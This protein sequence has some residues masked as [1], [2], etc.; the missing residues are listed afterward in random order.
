MGS[1]VELMLDVQVS[2]NLLGTDLDPDHVTKQLGLQPT[3]MFRRGDKKAYRTGRVSV[4]KEGYWSYVVRGTELDP[5]VGEFVSA[6]GERRQI[7]ESLPH[8]EK[9]SIEIYVLKPA[10]VESDAYHVVELT[11]AQLRALADYGVPFRTAVLIDL[12]SSGGLGGEGA[13]P[14]PAA[15]RSG[16][17]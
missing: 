5:V 13:S 3:D 10:Y 8:V 1:K 9:A 2:L 11:A 12:R 17:A 14:A 16:N 7:I 15:G 6:L 4:R